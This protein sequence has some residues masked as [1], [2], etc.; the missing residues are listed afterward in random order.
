MVTQAISAQGT[1]TTAAPLLTG[2]F[3]HAVAAGVDG[4]IYAF[5]GRTGSEI[6]G[7]A[8]AYDSGSDNWSKVASLPTAR[9]GLAAT[10]GPD[11]RI[12][13]AGG[14]NAGR[15]PLSRHMTQDRISGSK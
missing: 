4:T 8:E 5:G 7:D 12:C 11:G 3:L 2:R 10:V 6:I 15:S 9:Q 13:A 14:F 1:W